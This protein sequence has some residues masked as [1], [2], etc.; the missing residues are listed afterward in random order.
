MSGELSV[1]FN[2]DLESTAL[3][4]ELGGELN[5]LNFG[6][7]YP[8]I[9]RR[10]ESR[11]HLIFD[12]RTL[13]YMDSGGLGML[14]RVYKAISTPRAGKLLIVGANSMIRQMLRFTQLERKMPNFATLDLALA[15][16][17]T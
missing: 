17:S 14:L 11:F 2:E 16:L 3:V 15:N 10:A 13:H 9:E 6:E 8:E 5:W 1:K 7:L 4:I 12:L